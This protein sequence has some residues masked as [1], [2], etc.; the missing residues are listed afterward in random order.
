MKK[1]IIH[2]VYLTIVIILFYLS[3]VES[4]EATKLEKLAIETAKK[5]EMNAQEARQ[6]VA[7][8]RKIED[9]LIAKQQQLDSCKNQ[10]VKK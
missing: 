3:K 9:E 5:A 4:T 2:F 10:N 8:T 7:M 6:V 1:V